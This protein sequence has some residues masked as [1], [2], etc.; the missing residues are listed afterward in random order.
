[1]HDASGGDFN[2]KFLTA[3]IGF[4]PVVMT[5]YGP[6]RLLASNGIADLEIF[7]STVVLYSS[8]IGLDQWTC[9]L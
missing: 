9:A 7:Q 3:E 4:P 5:P 8:P 2:A 1:M 6:D